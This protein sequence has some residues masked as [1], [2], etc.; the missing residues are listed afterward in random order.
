MS[1]NL[2]YFSG[3]FAMMEMPHN[4]KRRFIV[5]L[6]M[7][8]SVYLFRTWSAFGRALQVYMAC[9]RTQGIGHYNRLNGKK[10]LR[11][12]M[13]LLKKKMLKPRGFGLLNLF[14]EVVRT[15]LDKVWASFLFLNTFKCW[16]VDFAAAACVALGEKE[17]ARNFWEQATIRTR[18]GVGTIHVGLFN[19]SPCLMF[20]MVNRS[21]VKG[22]GVLGAIM[23]RRLNPLHQC[24][25]YFEEV[26]LRMVELDKGEL[27]EHFLKHEQN[28][29][30]L[31]CDVF[32]HTLSLLALNSLK[33]ESCHPSLLVGLTWRPSAMW[34]VR[35]K[36]LIARQILVITTHF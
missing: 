14:L 22:Y 18:V 1:P 23:S 12:L 34:W 17:D 19:I 16:P 21:R 35:L 20:S 15:T 31:V 30:F 32:G 33:T 10:P 9:T 3:A 26:V 36:T 13:R 6:L 5:W 25:L 11:I 8:P 27:L 4:W 2:M 29:Y 28:K 24:F 7:L